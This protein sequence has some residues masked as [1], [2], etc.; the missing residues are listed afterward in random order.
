MGVTVQLRASRVSFAVGSRT[1]LDDVSVELVRGELLA[2]VGPNGAGK[3]TLLRVLAGDLE[4]SSG[5]VEL[6]GRPLTRYTAR[7]L[8]RVRAVLPQQTMLEFAFTACDVVEMGR[9]PWRDPTD[10]GAI[11]RNAM[12]RTRSDALAQQT[13]PTLSGG[14][15]ARVSLAR[16]LAQRPQ[17]FLLDE[18]TAAL[19]LAHQEL[20]MSIARS[21]ARAGRAVAVVVHDLNLAAAYADR[22]AILAAGRVVAC[23]PPWEA[24]TASRLERVFG[25]ALLVCP[26]PGRDCPLVVATG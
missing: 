4:P 21:L 17:V 14:E 3:S 7:E 22:I 10:D 15:Q 6:L 19:D 9:H 18:P 13:Y 24:L 20:A 5:M 16:V 1:L 26:H 11:V 8:A 23:A 2:I 25:H 12:V